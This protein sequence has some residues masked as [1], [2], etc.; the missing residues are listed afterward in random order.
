[1]RRAMPYPWR[2]PMV[3]RVWRTMRS[4]VPWRRSSFDSGIIEAPVVAPVRRPHKY[5]TRDVV[6]PQESDEWRFGAVLDVGDTMKGMISTAELVQI[7]LSPRKPSP[8][9][10]WLK[11]KA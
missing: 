1:M 2:V 11:A 7:D 5:V 9:P 10:A 6:M 8:K 4:R 3:V